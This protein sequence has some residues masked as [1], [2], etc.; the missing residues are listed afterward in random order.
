MFSSSIDSSCT[1][2]V[3]AFVFEWDVT[4]T[5]SLF[6]LV[7]VVSPWSDTIFPIPFCSILAY[8]GRILIAWYDPV[9]RGRSLKSSLSSMQSVADAISEV[10][11]AKT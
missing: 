11:S 7:T 3:S 6:S 10:H 8:S 5:F 9:I 1:G 2:L 4:S